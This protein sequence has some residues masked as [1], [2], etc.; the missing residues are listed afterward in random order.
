MPSQ[1]W[2]AV[3]SCGLFTH[4]TPNTTYYTHIQHNTYNTTH[5]VWRGVVVMC[6]VVSGVWCVVVW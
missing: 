6:S 1:R 4:N 2:T 5:G 3:C